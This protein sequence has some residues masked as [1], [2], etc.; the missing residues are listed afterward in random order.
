VTDPLIATFADYLASTAGGARVVVGPARHLPHAPVF[1]GWTRDGQRVRVVE[2]TPFQLLDPPPSFRVVAIVPTYNEADIIEHTVRYLLQDGIGVY[3]LDNWSTDATPE[4][5]ARLPLVGLERFPPSGPSTTYDLRRILGRV[6]QIAADLDADWVI[7][8]D[9]DE[10]RHGPWPEVGLRQALYMVERRGFTCIDHITLTFWPT[11]GAPVYDGTRD[12][13]EVLTWFE[14]SDHAGHFHQRR[15]WKRLPGERVDLASTA[16]HDV[17]FEGRRVF[18]YR[19]LLKHYPIR[20]QAHGERKVLAERRPRWNAAERAFGWHAQYD[21]LVDFVRHPS[22]LIR[23]D[24]ERFYADWL[25]ERLSGVGVFAEPPAW[26]TPPVWR[27]L[28]PAA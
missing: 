16:G 6:E 10:R 21:E 3:V 19:F 28:A 15:A 4:I 11:L 2:P 22:E 18:P 14:F 5:A 9:A 23:F 24:P 1:D 27:P 25:I 12:V 8:H 17:Q 20:S 13:E 26:A 7:L